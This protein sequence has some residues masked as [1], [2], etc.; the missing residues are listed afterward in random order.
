[1]SGLTIGVAAVQ[2]AVSEHLAAFERALEAEGLEGTV[3]P[4]RTLPQFLSVDALVLPGGEST[5]ISKLIDQAGIHDELVRRVREE[6]LPVM[7]TCA[8]MI[9]LASEGDGEVE[10]TGTRLLG[11]IDM[12]VDRNAFGRQRE[13]F[14]APVRI[15]LSGVGPGRLFQG[16]FI[17][18]PAV[19]KTWGDCQVLSEFDGRVVA[20]RQ[21]SVIALAFHPEL[22]DDMTLHRQ[23]L[24][25][26]V[27]FRD[28]RADN[29]R[30]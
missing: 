23:F 16:V 10:R 27:E 13:S 17:R 7:G 28:R 14:Q 26:V 2:G 4:V 6:G 20:V 3:I 1:M 9:L 19:R 18:A 11:L 5:S 8:G 29:S 30:S 24:L 12:A 15:D 22:S 21:G 25:T